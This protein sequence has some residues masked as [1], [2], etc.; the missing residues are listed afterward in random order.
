MEEEVDV[1]VGCRPGRDD[2]RVQGNDSQDAR[3]TRAHWTLLSSVRIEEP[4]PAVRFDLVCQVGDVGYGAD[5]KV[6]ATDED[7]V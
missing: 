6:G 2:P 1:S 5:L 3:L 7:L 4:L